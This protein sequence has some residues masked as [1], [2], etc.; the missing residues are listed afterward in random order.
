MSRYTIAAAV[1][2][3]SLACYGPYREPSLPAPPLATLPPARVSPSGAT[4]QDQVSGTT[5]R[6]QAISVVSDKIVWASGT[7]GTFVVTTNGGLSW[8]A[9]VVAGADSLEFRDVHGVDARIAWLLAAGPGPKSR[10]YYTIEIGRA[11]V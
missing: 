3:A 5:A 10:I 4:L 8:R 9:G 2:L 6:L 11:H 1:V 7:N